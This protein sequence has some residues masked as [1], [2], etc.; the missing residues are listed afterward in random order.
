MNTSNPIQCEVERLDSIPRLKTRGLRWPF[1]DDPLARESPG[2]APLHAG[3]LLMGF[4]N[5]N[6]RLSQHGAPP[7]PHTHTETAWS[8]AVCT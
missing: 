6:I 2:V 5:I 8:P 1:K 7:P 4:H 3:S